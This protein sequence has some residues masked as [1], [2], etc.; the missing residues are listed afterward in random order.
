MN[1]NALWTIA[2]ALSA[3]VLSSCIDKYKRILP[4]EYVIYKYESLNNSTITDL[5]DIKII[6]MSNKTF[7]LQVNNKEENGTWDAEEIQEFIGITFNFKNRTDGLTRSDATL[8]EDLSIIYIWNPKNFY[9]DS[10]R[11]L[12]FKRVS[13]L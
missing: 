6:L 10:L 3:L 8:E 9:C 2:I 1:R 13:K 11:K 12:S 7:T 4:G 5:P